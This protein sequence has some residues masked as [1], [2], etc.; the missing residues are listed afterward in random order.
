MPAIPAV[1]RSQL[2]ETRPADIYGMNQ[3][4]KNNNKVKCWGLKVCTPHSEQFKVKYFP[5]HREDS[6]PCRQ[7]TQT[8]KVNKIIIRKK[9][10]VWQHSVITSV[11]G[12]RD[13]SIPM[14]ARPASLVSLASSRCA[15]DPC[16]RMPPKVVP[17][18]SKHIY[19]CA[20]C[21]HTQCWGGLYFITNRF[22]FSGDKPLRCDPVLVIPWPSVG[23]VS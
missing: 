22:D 8:Y 12:V 18:S 7:N 1:R 17:L 9:K 21:E 6:W 20:F 19:V 11:Q 23:V 10:Q 4:L 14:G 16:W 13:K 3:G 15:V 2:Q 5:S